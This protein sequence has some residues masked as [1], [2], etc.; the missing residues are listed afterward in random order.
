MKLI[1]LPVILLPSLHVS[2][3][4]GFADVC[5]MKLISL[6]VILLPSLQFHSGQVLL[7][8]VAWSS[9]HCPWFYFHLSMF[10]S[11][12][13]L[14]IFVAWSSFHLSWFYFHL[15]ILHSGQT[16]LIFYIKKNWLV[17]CKVGLRDNVIRKHW[18]TIA[19]F[20]E[21]NWIIITKL[22]LFCI[23]QR[24]GLHTI[25][26]KDAPFISKHSRDCND[27]QTTRDIRNEYV[28]LR[29]HALQTI[30]KKAAKFCDDA[31]NAG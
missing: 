28:R 26:D 22:S 1:S 5:C 19:Y 20:Y 11:G 3:M 18:W 13:V 6:P 29:G 10:H 17:V 25:T 27:S 15:P 12:Q 2:L 9:F 4:T 30:T 16:L 31:N 23:I 24:N 8:F 21:L 7:M 14:L